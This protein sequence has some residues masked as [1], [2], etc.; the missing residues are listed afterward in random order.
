MIIINDIPN[1]PKKY[2]KQK[3]KNNLKTFWFELFWKTQNFAKINEI[4]RPAKYPLN[5][6]SIKFRSNKKIKLYTKKLIKVA[7]DPEITNL[8]I[9]I[10]F[11]FINLYNFII[12][13][14]ES[15]IKP[16]NKRS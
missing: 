2:I 4:I 3:I 16:S 11:S 15:C 10:L 6:A 13:R 7:I 9:C 5:E 8:I 1:A 14:Y 12:L